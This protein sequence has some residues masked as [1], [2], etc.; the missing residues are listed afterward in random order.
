MTVLADS[1]WAI[2][3]YDT[4]AMLRVR[5]MLIESKAGHTR[6]TIR[7]VD[8][9]LFSATFSDYGDGPKVSPEIAELVL[10]QAPTLGLR[11]TL[12]EPIRQVNKEASPNRGAA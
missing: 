6:V 12:E 4:Y 5:T 10:S 11:Q 3:T 9:G 8:R 2:D 1:V 7:K